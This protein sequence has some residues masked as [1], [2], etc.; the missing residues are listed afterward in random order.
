MLR[1]GSVIGSRSDPVLADRLHDLAHAGKLEVLSIDQ[2]DAGRGRLR[3]R[4]DQDTDCAITQPRGQRLDDGA[5]LLLDEE[6]AIVVRVGAER[7]LTVRPRD[8]PAALQLGYHAGNLHWRVRFADTDLQV[9]LEGAEADYIARLREM[10]DA[11][12]VT[13]PRD[14]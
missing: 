1:L 12:V 13:V 6:R 3:V 5:V 4:T 8:A 14:D 7:W 2:R 11:G 9:A 10:I